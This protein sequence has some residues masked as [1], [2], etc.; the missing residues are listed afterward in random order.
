[1]R[2]VSKSYGMSHLLAR[3]TVV[4]LIVAVLPRVGVAQTGPI[5]ADFL[6]KLERTACF[7]GCPVYSVTIDAQGNVTY[8]GI[9]FVRVEGEQTDRIPIPTV[10]ALLATA[11]RV[12]FFDLLDSYRAPISDLPTTYVT[13]TANGR[14]KR[15]EDYFRAPAGLKELERE[16]DE[17]A[18][19]ARWVRMDEQQAPRK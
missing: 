15:V 13:I 8:K 7:G 16:I 6:I 1:M 17:A 19:T 12:G 5:P 14:T 10:A 9:R 2:S 3:A 18:R 4:A 11:Q